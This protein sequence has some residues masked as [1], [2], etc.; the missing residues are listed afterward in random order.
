MPE[1]GRPLPAVEE[2][3]NLDSDPDSIKAYYAKWAESYDQDLE[4]YYTAPRMIVGILMEYLESGRSGLPPVKADLVLADAGC[5]TGLVGQVLYK[6][7]FR[8]IDGMD[9]SSDMVDKARELDVYRSLYGD[10]DITQPLRS[11]WIDAYHVVLCCG[12][13]TLG[14][15]P[16]TALHRLIEMAR[17]PGVVITSTRTAYYDTTDYQKV[18]DDFISSGRVELVKELRDAPYTADGNAHYWVYLT[19]NN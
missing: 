5:G 8:N 12:V 10:V 19:K 16:P 14:H 1:K 6:A 2:A 9:I 7:G 11:E 18:S 13:F 3:L 17:T 4:G 15:V